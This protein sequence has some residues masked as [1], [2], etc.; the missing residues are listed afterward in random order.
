MLWLEKRGSEMWSEERD[1]KRGEAVLNP[2]L[3]VKLP[4]S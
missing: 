1:T 3:Y 4:S 2:Q